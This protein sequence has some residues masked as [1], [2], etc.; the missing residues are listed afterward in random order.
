MDRIRAS[1]ISHGSGT[2]NFARPRAR[3]RR[4]VRLARRLLPE[5]TAMWFLLDREP[6]EGDGAEQVLPALE[7]IAR[8]TE[9]LRHRL[10]GDSGGG[11]DGAPALDPR[12]RTTPAWRGGS[13]TSSAASRT[14]GASSRSWSEA[15]RAGAGG[16][17]PLARSRARHVD[18]AVGRG[19]DAA[20]NEPLMQLVADR[21]E[22]GQREREDGGAQAPAPLGGE[23]PLHERAQDQV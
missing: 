16:E 13:P 15:L 10:A 7:A 23:R 11:V 20:G 14:S 4:C 8:F 1:A 9:E 18:Q 19:G 12:L 2:V 22:S 3:R 17:E 21:V 5:A 6:G